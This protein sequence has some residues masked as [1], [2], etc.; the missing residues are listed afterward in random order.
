[1]PILFNSLTSAHKDSSHCSSPSGVEYFVFIFLALNLSTNI[2]GILGSEP[3]G[4]RLR[5][6]S[7]NKVP[8]DIARLIQLD[9]ECPNIL[10]TS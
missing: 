1:M 3:L 10:A 9:T 8:F 7:A 6:G 2:L 5:R 4:P